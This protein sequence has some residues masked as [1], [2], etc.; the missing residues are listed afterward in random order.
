[1][2]QSQVDPTL[3]MPVVRLRSI[4]SS[5]IRDLLAHAAR[6]G[7]ISLAGGLPCATLFDAEGMQQALAKTME[8]PDLAMQYGQTEGE[9]L[10]REAIANLMIS[11]NAA[12]SSEQILITSG[13]QQALDLVARLVIEPDDLVLVERPA[14]LAALSAFRLQTDQVRDVACDDDGPIPAA[15]E[16]ITDSGVRP[17]M[18]YLVPNF[19]NPSGNTMSLQRRAAILSWAVTHRIIVVEDDPYGD[20]RFEGEPL[21]SLIALARTHEHRVTGANDWVIHLSTLS[22][23]VAPG[24]RIGWAVLPG[25]LMSAAVRLKQSMDLQT[26]TLMQLASMHYLASGR[27]QAHILGLKTAYRQRK[28]ALAESLVQN[29][30]DRLSLN[31]PAGGMFL[32]ARIGEPSPVTAG[33]WLI[34][35]L[36]AGVAFVPGETFYAESPDV[37]TLRLSFATG[38]VSQ[39]PVAALRLRQSFDAACQAATEQA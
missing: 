30:G 39:M 28:D 31:D 11:R 32:W 12:V 16:A 26:S 27:L 20:L 34:H 6:P 15:L 21:P 22:K 35:A 18:I 33:A 25:S 13:S 38:L 17:R 14:Y 4:R 37:H 7:M 3:P 9:P 10:L 36:D 2:P 29:F 1:M 8:R 23:I 24:L 5:P 19:A